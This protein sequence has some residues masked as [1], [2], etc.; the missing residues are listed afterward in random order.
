MKKFTIV[1]GVTFVASVTF[2]VAQ[3]WAADLIA[4]KAPPSASAPLASWAGLYIGGNAG[5]GFGTANFFDPDCFFCNDSSLHRGF[6]EAGG[7]AGYNWQF[8]HGV[9]GVEGDFN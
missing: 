5:G 4:T 7:Q 6:G 8:G 9:F 3:V 2:A 1:A